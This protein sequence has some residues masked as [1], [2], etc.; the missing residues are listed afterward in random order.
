V[1]S[2]VFRI[3]LTA[4]VAVV[5]LAVCATPMAFAAPGLQAV[6][7]LPAVLAAWVLRERTTID[8]SAVH[9]RYLWS[10]RRLPWSDLEGF[11]V[12]RSGAVR[13]VTHSGELV[14]LPG[15]RFTDL[16]RIAQVSGGAVDVSGDRGQAAE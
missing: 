9:A 7:L 8:A 5:V 14:R 13:A 4:L 11:V 15:V 1:E 10:S 6:Y 2:A 16:E 12:G 3:P